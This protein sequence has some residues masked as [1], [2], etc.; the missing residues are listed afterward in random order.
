MVTGPMVVSMTG[1]GKITNL[2]GMLVGKGI[3]SY[4]LFLTPFHS[5]VRQVWEN[6]I[7]RW[8]HI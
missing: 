6:D 3:Y 5:V 8:V 2:K 7:S 1:S 4:F